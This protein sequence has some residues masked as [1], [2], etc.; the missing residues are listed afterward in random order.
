MAPN[1]AAKILQHQ[2]SNPVE[3]PFNLAGVSIGDGW[4]NPVEQNQSWG[5]YGYAN[6]LLD[7]R[8][9]LE[10]DDLASKCVALLEE[11]DY[12]G[13]LDKYCYYNLLNK[14]V[15]YGGNVSPYDIRKSSDDPGKVFKT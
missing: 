2:K 7:S 14:V 12:L 4:V 13:G 11:G 9:K 5:V 10:I 15:E 3:S 8:Q 6:G 1:I